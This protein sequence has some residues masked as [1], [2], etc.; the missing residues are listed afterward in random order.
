[1]HE[2]INQSILALMIQPV[3]INFHAYGDML[4]SAVRGSGI[5][6]NSS[7]ALVTSGTRDSNTINHAG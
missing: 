3:P 7:F 6:I 4:A 2:R 1:M 5:D